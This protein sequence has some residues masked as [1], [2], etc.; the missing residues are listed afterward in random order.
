MKSAQVFGTLDARVLENLG[1]VPDRRFAARAR[2]QTAYSVP[3]TVPS[4]ASARR[5]VLVDQMP[6]EVLDRNERRP[7]CAKLATT[8]GCGR[9]ATSGGLPPSIFGPRYA[10]MSSPVDT[11]VT[12]RHRSAVRTG[13]EHACSKF[14]LLGA[15]PRR[16]HIDRS[17]SV[18]V[19]VPPTWS[20]YPKRRVLESLLQAAAIN[21]RIATVATAHHPI[22]SSSHS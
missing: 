1:V 22:A 7:G 16:R 15:G 6:G 9:I 21:V 17:A 14:R 13:V 8:P 2:N 20:P 3:S 11:N 10:A 18:Q 5:V 19:G 12:S 4:F